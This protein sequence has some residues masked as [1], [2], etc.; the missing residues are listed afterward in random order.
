MIYDISFCGCDTSWYEMWFMICKDVEGK[1]AVLFSSR[2]SVD[3]E[4]Y[5]LP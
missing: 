1:F 4:G 2:N 3:A 5:P